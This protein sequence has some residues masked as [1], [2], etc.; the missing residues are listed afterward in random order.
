MLYT[1]QSPKANGLALTVATEPGDGQNPSKKYKHISQALKERYNPAM[2]KA[3][4]KK[5]YFT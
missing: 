2:G 1:T 4:R 3:H 5:N